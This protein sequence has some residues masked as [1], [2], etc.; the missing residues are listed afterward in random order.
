MPLS[1]ERLEQQRD[2]LLTLRAISASICRDSSGNLTAKEVTDK[3]TQLIKLPPTSLTEEDTHFWL[4]YYGIN[5]PQSGVYKSYLGEYH[6]VLGIGRS[7]PPLD[8]YVIHGALQETP[9]IIVTSLYDFTRLANNREL[10]YTHI[11]NARQNQPYM[12]WA[13]HY[14]PIKRNIYS[15]LMWSDTALNK[16]LG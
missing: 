3:F 11:P 16:G 4:S 9:D 15:S 12:A 2:V 10:M 5:F 8:Y 14:E 7:D 1:P 13:K 6:I